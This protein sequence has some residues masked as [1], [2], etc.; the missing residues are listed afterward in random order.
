MPWRLCWLCCWQLTWL[1]CWIEAILLRLTC[2]L[3][4]M[5]GLSAPLLLRLWLQ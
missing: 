1:C 4:L 5:L 3:L 2:L